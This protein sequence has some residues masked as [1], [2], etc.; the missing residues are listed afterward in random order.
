MIIQF[1][2]GKEKRPQV[3]PK[4]LQIK[5]I[6]KKTINTCINIGMNQNCLQSYAYMGEGKF[7]I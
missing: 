6:V 1:G 5:I 4:Q 3:V 2:R 7:M